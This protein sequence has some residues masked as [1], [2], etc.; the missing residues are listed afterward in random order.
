[1]ETIITLNWALAS[2]AATTGSLHLDWFLHGACQAH[3]LAGGVL[4]ALQLPG[5][6]P[7]TPQV[8]GASH[9]ELLEVGDGQL[10]VPGNEG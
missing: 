6:Q 4:L 7:R 2:L 8:S 10:L 5:Q 9:I 1:M 3:H